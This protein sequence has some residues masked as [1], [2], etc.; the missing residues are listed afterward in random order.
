MKITFIIHGLDVVR[1]LL[2]DSDELP[3]PDSK[4]AEQNIEQWVLTKKNKNM[5]ETEDYLND[6]MFTQLP[7][8]PKIQ[9]KILNEL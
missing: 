3:V 5:T 9:R 1:C 2:K 8:K 7:C 6:R 4:D